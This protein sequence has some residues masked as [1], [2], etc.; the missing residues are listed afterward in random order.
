[1]LFKFWFWGIWGTAARQ[2]PPWVRP[3]QL[4]IIL[5]RLLKIF[6]SWYSFVY[7]FRNIEQNCST[8]LRVQFVC[9]RHFYC[10]DQEKSKYPFSF[11]VIIEP[12]SFC[13]IFE[14]KRSPDVVNDFS[15]SFQFDRP[16]KLPYVI[17]DVS[18]I[19]MAVFM[20][21]PTFRLK[22]SFLRINNLKFPKK[23]KE[24]YFLI[25]VVLSSETRARVYTPI[26]LHHWPLTFIYDS[27]FGETCS[28]CCNYHCDLLCRVKVKIVF[29]CIKG[30]ITVRRGSCLDN[31]VTVLTYIKKSRVRVSDGMLANL[32]F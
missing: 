28:Y 5:L 12:S 19:I 10:T 11:L 32:T 25:K 24:V 21:F 29:L 17:A 13:I 23:F 7:L 3:C 31:S 8:F 26:T 16:I 1:M 18:V 15:K 22:I 27:V 2:S 9:S 14:L 30:C 6:L 4:P 20:V